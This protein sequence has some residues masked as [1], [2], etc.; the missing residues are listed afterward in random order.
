[1]QV[2]RLGRVPKA[3]KKWPEARIAWQVNLESRAQAESVPL[4]GSLSIDDNAALFYRGRTRLEASMQRIRK[5]PR[6]ALRYITTANLSRLQIVGADFEAAPTGDRRTG[7]RLELQRSHSITPA[8]HPVTLDSRFHWERK[9]LRSTVNARRDMN[10][11]SGGYEGTVGTQLASSF[12][13]G[14]AL[15]GSLTGRWLRE[16]NATLGNLAVDLYGV[17]LGLAQTV[18]KTGRLRLD[19]E[20]L[21][22]RASEDTPLPLAMAEGLPVGRS[23]R[24]RFTGQVPLASNLLMTVSFFSRAQVGGKAVRT[25]N[26]QLRTRL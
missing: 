20:L 26:L 8:A 9:E 14:G 4:L 7:N 22:V 24:I 10:I 18:G 12:T 15:S 25:A 11:T 6:Y 3:L 21:E 19:I 5:G 2:N 16:T 13:K 23:T 17:T 1:M